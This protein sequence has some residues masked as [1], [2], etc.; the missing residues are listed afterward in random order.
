MTLRS[1][2][3]SLHDPHALAYTHVAHQRD[4]YGRAPTE[5]HG[6]PVTIAHTH[7]RMYIA[8]TRVGQCPDT[9]SMRPNAPRTRPGAPDAGHHHRA[10]LIC[11]NSIQAATSMAFGRVRRSLLPLCLL[12]R[13][14]RQVCPGWDGLGQVSAK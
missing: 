9:S 5:R 3:P 8:C 4:Q 12:A 1:T 6:Q 14:G 13:G 2:P 7:A 11:A 10:W